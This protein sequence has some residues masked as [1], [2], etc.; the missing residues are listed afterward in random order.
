MLQGRPG[1]LGT[2]CLESFVLLLL[3]VPDCA[4]SALQVFANPKRLVVGYEEAQGYQWVGMDGR[5][6]GLPSPV[7]TQVV[8]GG[9]NGAMVRRGDRYSGC[10][11]VGVFNHVHRVEETHSE[12]SEMSARIG[13][14]RDPR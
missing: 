9:R 2:K 5:E 8:G 10:E 13:S 4:P 11:Y 6:Y 3:S 1:E 12:L 7:Q 14:R